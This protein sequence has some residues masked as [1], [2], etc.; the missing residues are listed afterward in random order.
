MDTRVLLT[1]GFLWKPL[2]TGNEGCYVAMM[3]IQQLLKQTSYVVMRNTEE[4]LKQR[5]LTS[6]DEHRTA[7]K[8]SYA[9]MRTIV[10]LLKQRMLPSDDEQ[11]QL[12]RLLCENTKW[13]MTPVQRRPEAPGDPGMGNC[14]GFRLGVRGGFRSGI[15]GGGSGSQWT[16]PGQRPWSLWRQGRG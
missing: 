14:G 15:G 4:L 5:M 3:N 2:R 9:V 10:E 12:L 7:S 6:D 13:R 8:T 16:R 11:E 1:S